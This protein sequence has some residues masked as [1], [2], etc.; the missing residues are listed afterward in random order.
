VPAASD[1]DHIPVD[2]S[3]QIRQ[4]AYLRLI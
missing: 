4:S 2:L 1:N 3:W